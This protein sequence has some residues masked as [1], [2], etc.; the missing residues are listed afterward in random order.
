MRTTYQAAVLVLALTT[1]AVSLAPQ[2]ALAQASRRD[3]IGD[4]IA[5][6]GQPSDNTNPAQ[7]Q[8]PPSGRH[9]KVPPSMSRPGA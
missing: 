6:E 3:N 9:G 7:Q 1:G 2:D 4:L 5:R 8:V